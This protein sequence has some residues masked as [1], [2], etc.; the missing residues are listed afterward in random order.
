[1]QDLVKQNPE[2]ATAI[3]GALLGGGAGAMLA[4]KGKG[5]LGAAGGAALG[6]GAAY[7][8]TNLLKEYKRRQHDLTGAVMETDPEK[9]EQRLNN[10]QGMSDRDRA[11]LEPTMPKAGKSIGLMESL[12][13]SRNGG[14]APAR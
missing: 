5:I 10:V 6:G 14:S 4:P 2:I 13:R 7:T 11:L 8:I 9:R 12:F 1:V 3:A